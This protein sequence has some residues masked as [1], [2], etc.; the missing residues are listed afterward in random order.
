MSLHIICRA[1]GGC[2]H[3]SPFVARFFVS[4]S[5]GIGLVMAGD[6]HSPDTDGDIRI[7]DSDAEGIEDINNL[8]VLASALALPEVSDIIHRANRLK[9][10]RGLLIDQ[11]HDSN[12]APTMLDRAG[13]RTLRNTLVH[14]EAKV[15]QRI[16][17]AWRLGARGR[18]PGS[19]GDGSVSERHWRLI[20]SSQFCRN[21]L[22]VVSA[23]R[24]ERAATNSVTW[25]LT[26]RRQT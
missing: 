17:N 8:F 19:R 25:D 6:V 3:G 18:L 11:G 9:H 26:A 15:F 5:T 12:W 24:S 16:L 20:C 14:S 22:S 1:T 10:L 2:T 13:L 4:V 21:G 7:V 23:M